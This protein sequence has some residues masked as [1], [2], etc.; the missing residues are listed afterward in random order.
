[1]NS[2]LTLPILERLPWK[3]PFCFP[4]TQSTSGVHRNTKGK[5]IP[6]FSKLHEV[7]KKTHL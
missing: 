4:V 5:H 7:E 2:P 3:S 6:Q 1:M